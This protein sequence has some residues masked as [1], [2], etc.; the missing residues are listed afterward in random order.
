[1]AGF[2]DFML[3]SKIIYVNVDKLNMYKWTGHLD[4]SYFIVLLI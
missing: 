4:L 2:V 1:M 3:I